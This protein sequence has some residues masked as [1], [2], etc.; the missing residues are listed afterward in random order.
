MSSMHISMSSRM[1]VSRT[2]C[3][4]N[5]VSDTSEKLTG[6]TNRNTPEFIQIPETTSGQDPVAHLQ[7]IVE[8]IQGSDHYRNAFRTWVE[9]GNK[10]GLFVFQNTTVQIQSKELLQDVPTR[11]ASTENMIKRCISMRLVSL[12]I[13]SCDPIWMTIICLR[14]SIPSS[15]NQDVVSKKAT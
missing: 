8:V 12:S 1:F 3:V 15:H 6:T 7:K 14:L 9:I 11:W 13:L 2:G 10:S 5:N 4:E